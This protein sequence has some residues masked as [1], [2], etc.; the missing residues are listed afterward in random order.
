MP[1]L[2]LLPG[3]QIQQA[4]AIGRRDAGQRAQLIGIG[5]AARNANPDHEMAR[6]RIPQKQAAPLQTLDIGFRDR[7]PSRSRIT[8]DQLL[9][10]QA[11]PLLFQQFNFIHAPTLLE[12]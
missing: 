3:R 5:L 1:K 7:L 9:D 2:H 4:V 12:T 6:R 8:R 10:V 11:V